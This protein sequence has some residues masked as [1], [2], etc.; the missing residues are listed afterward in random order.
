[1]PENTPEQNRN[2]EIDQ[3]ISE[4]PT[5]RGRERWS[6]SLIARTVGWVGLNVAIVCAVS[7]VTAFVAFYSL[8]SLMGMTPEILN[9]TSILELENTGK[10]FPLTMGL[11]A[12][13]FAGAV[14][15]TETINSLRSRSRVIL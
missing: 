14:V 15:T 12:G 4:L 7:V 8:G 3:P 1:M 9:H 6:V 10:L 2:L 13:Q 11:L 5:E